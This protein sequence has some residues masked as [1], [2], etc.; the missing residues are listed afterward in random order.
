VLRKLGER[1]SAPVIQ[2]TCPIVAHRLLAASG[3]LRS[4]IISLVAPPVALARYLRELCAPVIPR[5]TYVGRCTAAVDSSIDAHITPEE[6]IATFSDLGID[7]LTQPRVFESVIPP[8]RRRHFSEPGGVPSATQLWSDGGGRTLV[9]LGEGNVAI[10]VAKLLLST[11]DVLI[12]ASVR[13][14]C[15]CAGANPHGGDP[16]TRARVASIEPPR[17]SSPVIDVRSVTLELDLPIPAV[18][19]TAI[20]AAVDGKTGPAPFAGDDITTSRRPS[21]AFVEAIRQTPPR[22]TQALA[23][24]TDVRPKHPSPAGR[25]V[26]GSAP[27]VKDSVGRQLPRTYIARRRS[28]GRGIAKLVE[29]TE[30]RRI[31]SAEAPT[32]PTSRGLLGTAPLIAEAGIPN[33]TRPHV[34]SLG[35]PETPSSHLAP[36]ATPT[37]ASQASSLAATQASPPAAAQAS[38][39]AAAQ[40]SPPAAAQASPPAAAQASP[41]VASQAPPP[42]ASHAPPRPAPDTAKLGVPASTSSSWRAGRATISL[43]VVLIVLLTA[44]VTVFVTLRVV[45]RPPPAHDVR[46]P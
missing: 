38:P 45:D 25:P 17:S 24:A 12:D 19:R 7:L 29:L 14:G 22:T 3:D 26:A 31:P 6:L 34:F 13:L 28:P 37:V 46:S 40:A 20:D 2:C 15:V 42:A 41:P 18:S 33:S 5:I 4:S 39:P 8:D 21:P 9:E 43:V 30:E 35:Q 44:V 16:N 36:D 1:D 27:V 11:H 23:T 32:S 10:E